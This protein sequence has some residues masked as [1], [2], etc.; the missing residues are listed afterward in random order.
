MAPRGAIFLLLVTLTF[1]GSQCSTRFFVKMRTNSSDS[2][3]TRADNSRV[4]EQP[5][6][7]TSP[8][9]DETRSHFEND[10][11]RMMKEFPRMEEESRNTF[12]TST[13][14]PD[15]L[16]KFLE[17]YA[18]KIKGSTEKYQ[19]HPF[20][21]IKPSEAIGLE[22]D[23][24]TT[25]PSS[26][27]YAQ[28]DKIEEDTTNATL[29]E[30]EISDT[31]NDTLKR[32]KYYGA[33]SYE[34]RNGW[35]TLEAIP[36][37]KSK[38][39]KWQATPS[40]Q[41]PWPEVKPWEKPSM[42]KPWASDYSVRPIYE[43]NKPWYDKPKPNWPENNEKPWQK[44][45]PRP[46]YYPEKPDENQAQ[47]WPPE[48]PSW[49]KYT[50]R[51]N[52]DII[53]DNRPANFPSNWNR[54]QT[55]KPGYQYL[56]RYPDKNQ[57]EENKND[58]HDFPTRYD[59]RLRPTTERPGFSQYQYVNNHP[60]S[61]PGNSDG[62]WVLLSTN[63]GY[64]KS[65]QRSMKIDTTNPIQNGSRVVRVK[66][67]EPDP[68]ITVMT[69]K[70]QVRLTVLPSI[71]GTNTTTSHGG[72]L[73][74]EKT[75]KSVDQSQ[76]EYEMKKQTLPVIL[77]KRPIRNT[78]GNQASNSAVL[79]A[80]SAGILPATM[81]M[82]IPMILGRRKRGLQASQSRLLNYDDSVMNIHGPTSQAHD[83]RLR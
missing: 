29:S 28:G 10:A 47:K 2:F 18:N 51:P 64:S 83:T 57:A 26:T 78:L 66:G 69:S 22:V 12:E 19:K 25:R 60:Q 82:M 46:S 43:N 14:N 52:S 77:K 21:I 50:D 36:W 20:R 65:R 27:T 1:S 33:N 74:V 58:W 16:N 70:R 31:L 6:A 24:Q 67:E 63:R 40:T 34:D 13:F 62:Q 49:N 35:V 56:D 42:A 4:L 23:V 80:V 9:Q 15:V 8:L 73:E 71:N 32:N 39:S 17:E 38:I 59:D 37:S 61:Y 55:A 5:I 53:T 75:F 41:Q 30:E 76:K 81:A 7:T 68:A 48:R 3:K 72:L 54:P 45:T 44:P 11:Q 79:A